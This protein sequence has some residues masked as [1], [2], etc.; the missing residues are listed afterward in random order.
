M[1][2]HL[3]RGRVVYV[4]VRLVLRSDRLGLYGWL[5]GNG[6]GLSAKEGLIVVSEHVVDARGAPEIMRRTSHLAHGLAC[7]LHHGGQPFGAD[8]D[9]E[10]DRND[11]ELPC[12]NAEHQSSLP[13]SRSNGTPSHTITRG[14]LRFATG[15]GCP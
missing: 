2:R 9:Q 15:R 6:I 13:H 3:I 11:D 7:G 14:R 10:H 5:S 1:M 4:C 12:T 8:R